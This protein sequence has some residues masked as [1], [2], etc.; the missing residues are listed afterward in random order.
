MD[1]SG[2]WER[3]FEDFEMNVIHY[4]EKSGRGPLRSAHLVKPVGTKY[5]IIQDRNG[6]ESRIIK[7]GIIVRNIEE[8]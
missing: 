8:G 4:Y 1:F 7:K 5:I 6:V 2:N 3:T